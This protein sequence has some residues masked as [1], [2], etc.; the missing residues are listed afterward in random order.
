MQEIIS[1][2]KLFADNPEDIE[3]EKNEIFFTRFEIE[4][5]CKIKD[6]TD[7]D[8]KIYYD[9]ELLLSYREFL[10]KL[11]GIDRLARRIKD[12]VE[13][14]SVYIKPKGELYKVDDDKVMEV[15]DAEKTLEELCKE[16]EFGCTK[17]VFLT[18]NAGE[19]KTTLLRKLTKS[20][21]EKYLK[22]END[23]LMFHIESYGGRILTRIDD[24]IA[25]YLDKMRVPGLY[26]E[27]VV[28]L[29]QEG[30]IVL[31]IDG[32]DELLAADIKGEVFTGLGNLIR[33]MQGEGTII[34]ASRTTFYDKEHF[35][36]Q[37]K[38]LRKIG[39]PMTF[40]RLHLKARDRENT[41]E[42]FR[43]WGLSNP[44]VIYDEISK[45][46]EDKKSEDAIL[47]RPL[48]VKSLTEMLLSVP[49]EEIYKKI[50]QL[51]PEYLVPD[52]IK[53]YIVREV[54]GKWRFF[55]N[56]LIEQHLRLLGSIAN[57]LWE[58]GTDKIHQDIIK[59]YA[60]MICE[61]EN[62]TKDKRE[63]VKM[64]QAHAL[65]PPASNNKN[66]RCFIHEDFKNYSLAYYA[67]T[68][69]RREYWGSVKELLMTGQLPIAAAEWIWAIDNDK[70]TSEQIYKILKKL[71]EMVEDENSFELKSNV[72]SLL[73]GAIKLIEKMDGQVQ[74][75]EVSSLIFNADIWKNRKLSYVIFKECEFYN[76]D[77]SGTHWLNCTFQDC[78]I[79]DACYDDNT[80]LTN[81][82]FINT[83][84]KSMFKSDEKREYNQFIIRKLIEKLGASW[85]RTKHIEEEM[86]QER[87]LARLDGRNPCGAVRS[88]L[89]RE[90]LHSRRERK[91][92]AI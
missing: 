11:S 27:G 87:A 84:L 60:E 35:Q 83:T 50:E 15:S 80:K 23:W 17:I 75:S 10:R 52:F 9:K 19:G 42:Y 4:R 46:L 90:R 92:L 37:K 41:I 1:D 22:R 24:L 6:L 16:R 78:T 34:A 39:A 13:E 38:L 74:F 5:T 62:I 89:R 30:L 66:F 18:A 56:F 67:A 49:K 61:D 3:W 45:K 53:Y 48:L 71:F 8:T 85:Q 81:S 86:A 54:E 91:R 69:L 40:D 36:Y 51:T 77:I 21:A 58:S 32:L 28:R 57:D 29:I 59:L 65:L 88:F 12:E 47:S 79:Y 73:T 2:I 33:E 14:I 70:W 63:I 82:I 72:G 44:E 76:I 64:A 25:G 43:K 68:L 7:K 20:I 55:E 31:S 26:Y